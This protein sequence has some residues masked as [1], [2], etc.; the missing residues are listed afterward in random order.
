[1]VIF[2]D[3]NPPQ[4]FALRTD[5]VNTLRHVGHFAWRTRRANARG[6]PHVPLHV[7]AD[8]VGAASLLEIMQQAAGAQFS[9]WRNVKS[10]GLPIAPDF[11]IAVGDIEP[12]SIRRYSNSVRLLNNGLADDASHTSIPVDAVDSFTFHLDV[13]SI[14][15][16]RIGEP[17]S[18]D[19]V[20]TDIVGTVVP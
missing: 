1:H 7:R 3:R 4:Q 17:D 20:H 13:G 12:I 2:R 8:A 16:A 14:T 6:D 19:R 11:V 10:P 5:D 18:A 9:R 15:V